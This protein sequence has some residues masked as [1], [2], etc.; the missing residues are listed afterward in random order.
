MK[1]QTVAEL[2]KALQALPQ[3]LPVLVGCHY[4]NDNGL[5]DQVDV[6]LSHVGHSE[7]E[8]YHHQDPSSPGFTVVTID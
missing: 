5:T 1:V 4:D 7:A 3:H 6:G 2:V 8:F